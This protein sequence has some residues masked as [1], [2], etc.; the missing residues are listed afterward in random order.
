MV[1]HLQHSRRRRRRCIRLFLPP[2]LCFYSPLLLLRS[3]SA[4]A[5]SPVF[6]VR[7]EQHSKDI[8]AKVMNH[9]CKVKRCCCGGNG[10]TKPLI[11][12]TD[13]CFCRAPRAGPPRSQEENCHHKGAALLVNAIPTSCHFK[14]NPA[15][16][17]PLTR[18]RLYVTP[19][20]ARVCAR[21]ARGTGPPDMFILKTGKS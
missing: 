21:W 20:P 14:H 18:C 3:S 5:S 7:W 4:A 1:K 15:L 17:F 8:V 19:T 16:F 11:F 2:A 10:N 9:N 13:S 6:Q 12:A